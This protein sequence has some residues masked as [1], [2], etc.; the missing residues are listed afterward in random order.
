MLDRIKIKTL[1][2]WIILGL[3]TTNIYINLDNYLMAYVTTFVS[4]IAI[5]IWILKSLGA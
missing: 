1:K 5:Y 2:F 3:L 4:L